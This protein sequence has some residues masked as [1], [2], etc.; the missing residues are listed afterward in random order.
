MN[1]EGRKWLMEE[2]SIIMQKWL[3][4]ERA[5]PWPP[6]GGEAG[7]DL[8]GFSGSASSDNSFSGRK[9][10]RKEPVFPAMDLL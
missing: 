4:T 3:M 7:E 1:S 2:L 9:K 10:I 8:F 6:G 5:R